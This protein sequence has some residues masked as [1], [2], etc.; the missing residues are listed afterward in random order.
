MQFFA[1]FLK[2]WSIYH[3]QKWDTYFF[4]T[5]AFMIVQQISIHSE[6]KSPWFFQ[7]FFP[8]D[9]H[10]LLSLNQSKTL[11]KKKITKNLI[12]WHLATLRWEHFRRNIQYRK[13]DSCLQKKCWLKWKNFHFHF[14][15]VLGA[16][17]Q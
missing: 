6:W 3:E 7:Y 17:Y 15:V 8:Q 9:S 10:T 4:S 14:F 11:R 16:A 13:K 2:I 5:T 1:Q 12:K